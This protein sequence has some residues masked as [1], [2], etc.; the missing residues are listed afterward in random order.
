MIDVI[1][2]KKN[3]SFIHVHASK[4]I[5][6]ELREH[7]KFFAD[8]YKF[9]P[10]FKA[11]LWTGEIFLLKLLTSTKGEIYCGLLFDIIKFCS[12]RNYSYDINAE[13]KH[14]VFKK[15]D[16]VSYANNMK[17]YY[18]G[19]QLQ[20][21]DYQYDGIIESLTSGRSIN[22]SATSSGKS[23]II[24]GIIRYLNSKDLK[25]LLIVPNLSL[26]N[27]MQ[28]DFMNYSSKDS[29]DM[30]KNVHLIYQGQNKNTEKPIVFSTWQS[31]QQNN[32]KNRKWFEQFD[33]VLVDECHLAAATELRNI[34]EPCSNAFYR[35]GFTGTLSDSKCN[36]H[37]LVGL[38]GPINQLNTTKQLIDRGQITDL[39]IHCLILKHPELT[40]KQNKKFKYRDEIKF[41]VTNQKRN[42]FI[43]NLSLSMKNNTIVIF[44]FIE[45]GKELYKM[46][47]ESKHKGNRNIYLIY[48]KV[49]A[50]EREEIR[51]IMETE[52]DAIILGSSSIMS[53]GVSIKNLHNI[54]FAVS[55]KSR[56][57]TLQ[58]IGRVLRLHDSKQK[59]KLFDIVD[60]CSYKTYKNFSL[61]HF[62]E[63][64]KLYNSEKFD[65][66]VSTINL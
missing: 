20:I 45:H 10:K 60:D 33:Y 50:E 35:F 42:L 5:L 3:E 59:A 57:R 16:I 4:S 34:L 46:I 64:L 31:L 49:P 26:I 2:E 21:R 15:E 11:K 65:Y 51:K 56:I 18:E 40:C 53:T 43:K 39:K 48:G 30:D 61:T 55:G 13:W 52:N 19:K 24:Y 38:F 9:H 23:L 12:S 63:R 1:I 62:I 58:S 47:S 7:F 36:K 29:W 37:T 17:V 41:L 22:I 14:S 66:K 44:N 8:N 27:Q 25:G 54:I 6:F 32:L 28:S